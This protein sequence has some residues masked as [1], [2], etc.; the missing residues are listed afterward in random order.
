MTD[1]LL[2][3][4][5]RKAAR[6]AA[7]VDIAGDERHARKHRRASHWLRQSQEERDGRAR[8]RLA[9]VRHSREET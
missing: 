1:R 3:A 5:S 2:S 6:T 8:A 4:L 7:G 9:R